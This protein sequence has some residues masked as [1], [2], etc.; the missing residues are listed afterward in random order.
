MIKIKQLIKKVLIIK[1]GQIGISNRTSTSIHFE[2][3]KSNVE[4]NISKVSDVTIAQVYT[5][6]EIKISDKIINFLI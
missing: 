2:N 3:V 6:A 4:P 5:V 1:N